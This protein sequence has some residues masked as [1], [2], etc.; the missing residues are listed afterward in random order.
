MLK[1]ALLQGL[2]VMN[3]MHEENVGFLVNKDTKKVTLMP[4][5]DYGSALQLDWNFKTTYN[6]AQSFQC[7]ATRNTQSQMLQKQANN[8]LNNTKNNV[9]FGVHTPL[10]NSSIEIHDNN[11]AHSEPLSN[12]S[13]LI[14]TRELA[15]E[16]Q[17]NDELRNFYERLKR[18]IDFNQIRDFYANSI[19]PTTN[20]P[21]VPEIYIGTA[22]QTFKAACFML[23]KEL[24]RAKNSAA[25][26][27]TPS[28][29]Q[30]R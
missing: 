24:A 23:D 5:Y 1:Q 17:M 29:T 20:E 18:Q 30:S 19:D 4:I 3:D 16:M 12:D 11:N 7:S 10:V 13:L 28:S 22:E 14:L 21:L 27:E 25:N 9:M 15:Q 8:L 2:F 26:K 6:K